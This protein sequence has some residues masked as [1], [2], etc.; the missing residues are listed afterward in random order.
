MLSIDVQVV[1]Q[2]TM[3]LT[4]MLTGKVDWIKGTY[5]PDI[6]LV[7]NIRGGLMTF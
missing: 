4:E 6:L 5:H 7:D 3:D 2:I 1:D